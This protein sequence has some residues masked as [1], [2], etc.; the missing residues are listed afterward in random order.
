MEWTTR[1]FLAKANQWKLLRDRVLAGGD[2]NRQSGHVCYAERQLSMWCDFA[3]HAQS[4]YQI[5]NPGFVYIPVT[6]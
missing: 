2:M 3:V 5:V 6:V 4:R 1:Y